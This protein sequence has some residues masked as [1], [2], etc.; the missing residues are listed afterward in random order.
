LA[1][2]TLSASDQKYEAIV[3]VWKC[4]YY[5]WRLFFI[6]GGAYSIGFAYSTWIFP[7]P[8]KKVLAHSSD[9]GH[10]PPR[11][12]LGRRNMLEHA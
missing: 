9:T 1:D 5:W 7:Y 8:V 6:I 3:C 10:F 4:G 2:T 11:I 12:L